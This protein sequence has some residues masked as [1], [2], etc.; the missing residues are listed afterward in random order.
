MASVDTLADN[1]QTECIE[2]QNDPSEQE[3]NDAYRIGSVQS[4]RQCQHQQNQ[5]QSQSD[6][7]GKSRD[8]VR[9]PAD[10][11]LQSNAANGR[12]SQQLQGIRLRKSGGQTDIW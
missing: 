11:K 2:P 12:H 6:G 1:G 10:G 5:D 4:R 3:G 7:E 9:K 8:L